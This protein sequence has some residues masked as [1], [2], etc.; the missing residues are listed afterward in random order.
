M[1]I[2]LSHMTILTNRNADLMKYFTKEMYSL[3]CQIQLNH[4]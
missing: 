4:L 1:E 3:I 2:G